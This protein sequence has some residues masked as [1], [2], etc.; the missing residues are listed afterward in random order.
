MDVNIIG[1][2]MDITEAMKAH[3]NEKVGKLPHFLDNLQSVDVCFA[4]DAGEYMVEIVAHGKRKSTFV[5]THRGDNIYGCLDQ[6]IHKMEQ[7]IRKHKD[8]T[9]DHQGPTHEES[10]APEQP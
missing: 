10:M 9:R 3:A 7:Q 1:R 2:H 6:C 8:R 4:T 5:A